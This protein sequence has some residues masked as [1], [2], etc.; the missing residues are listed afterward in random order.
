MP[1][2]TYNLSTRRNKPW[3]TDAL[4]T[5]IKRKSK[6][7]K[8]KNKN[9]AIKEMYNSYR[10]KLTHLL[11]ISRKEYFSKLFAENKHNLK[12]VLENN[13]SINK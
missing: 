2:I 4:R 6:L 3:I 10:N 5:S 1:K 11:R 12:K 9:T 7:Y 13:K 8:I